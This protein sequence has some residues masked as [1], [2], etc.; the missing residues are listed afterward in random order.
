MTYRD[1]NPHAAP[2]NEA[3]ETDGWQDFP[4]DSSAGDPRSEESF[5][6]EKRADKGIARGRRL[7][8]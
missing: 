6:L 1:A 4:P 7:H 8:F 5:R 3:N 2:A